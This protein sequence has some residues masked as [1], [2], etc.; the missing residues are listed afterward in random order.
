MRFSG[1]ESSESAPTSSG[2]AFS[3]TEVSTASAYAQSDSVVAVPQ[4]TYTVIDGHLLVVVDEI[5]PGA[6]LLSP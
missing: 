5:P 1:T 6:K 4:V 2:S 3:M